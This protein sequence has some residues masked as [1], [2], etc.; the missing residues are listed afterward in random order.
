MFRLNEETKTDWWEVE[1]LLDLCF[2]PGRTALSSYRL[3][4]GVQPIPSL[5][6][7]LRDNEGMVAASIRYWPVQVVSLVAERHDALLL[8]PLAVH[9]IRQGEGL[10]RLLI[11]E[12]LNRARAFGAARIVMVGD[13]AYYQRFGFEKLTN[14]IMP[15]PTNPERVLGYELVPDAWQGIAGKVMR[16]EQP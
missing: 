16:I 6:L 1:L 11:V 8:G 4:E 10:G 14:I 15:E 13:A 2:A 5:C 12:S 7:L 9:P 3:R